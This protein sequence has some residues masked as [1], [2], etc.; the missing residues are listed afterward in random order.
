MSEQVQHIPFF[1]QIK[2]LSWPFWAMNIMEMIERLAYYGVRVVIPIYIAQADAIGGLHFTQHDK[3]V[4]FFWWALVQCLLPVFTGGF[5][6]RYGYK[7]QIFVSILL[8]IVGYVIMATQVQFWGFFAGCMVLA[9]G[10][11]VFK[12][13]IQ[14]TMIKTL[15]PKN[16]GVGWG[17]FYQVVNIGG[18][19]GP[20]LA[21]YLY[22]ISWP[23]VFYGCAVIVSLNFLMLLTYKKIDSEADKTTGIMHVFKT[24][25][26]NIIKPRLFSFILIMSLFWAAFMQLWDLLPNFI[27]DWVDSSSIAQFLPQAMLATDMSRGPQIAQE[28]VINFNPFMIIFFVVPISWYVNK[29]MRRLSSIMLGMLVSAAALLLLGYSMLGYFTLLGIAGFSVGEMLCSPKMNEYLGVIAP[30]DQKALYMGYANMPFAIG[31]GYGSFLASKIYA[32]SGE[33]A[34]LALRYLSEELHLTDLPGR[35]ESFKVMMQELGV[36]ATQATQILWD[37]YNPGQVWTPIALGAAVAAVGIMIY[38]QFAKKWADAN[39]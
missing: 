10:T 39:A 26:K 5:A 7:I 30:K 4:I 37:M 16:S 14:G 23:T 15:T 11:A 31:W 21:H 27:V 36:N 29:K 24:T 35:T 13:P 9:T 32:E 12:P 34:G 3:G 17:F 19:F 28:W 20:P 8:K 33:K 2:E 6:D 25:G 1:K 38:N 18:F 22:G